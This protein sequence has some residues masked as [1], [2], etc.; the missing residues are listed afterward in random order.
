MTCR[1]KYCSLIIFLFG[2]FLSCQC[3][4]QEVNDHC[5]N[6]PHKFSYISLYSETGSYILPRHDVLLND[7]GDVLE[8]YLLPLI[9]EVRDKHGKPIPGAWITLSSNNGGAG[10]GYPSGSFT[11]NQGMA[12]TSYLPLFSGIATVEVTCLLDNGITATDSIQV[13]VNDLPFTIRL[14]TQF[15]EIAA[16]GFNCN[17]MVCAEMLS[18]NRGIIGARLLFDSDLGNFHHGN[19]SIIYSDC[20]GCATQKWYPP[21][22]SIH[23]NHEESTIDKIIATLTVRNY[24]DDDSKQNLAWTNIAIYPIHIETTLMNPADNNADIPVQVKT[25]W[26][27]KEFEY[28][29]PLPVHLSLVCDCSAYLENDIVQTNDSGIGQT[30]IRNTSG[31][32]YYNLAAT[33]LNKSISPLTP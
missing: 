20:H 16:A 33:V 26:A 27:T 11:N 2:L 1:P 28:P 30:V 25:W 10:G 21:L 13:I 7:D 5:N 6:K 4:E 19:G 32:N 12:K 29:I 17:T 24:G 3:C 22:W 18:F 8:Q 23:D 31:C 14:F 15:H 9:V